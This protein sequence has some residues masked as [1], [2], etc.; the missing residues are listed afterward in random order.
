MEQGGFDPEIE[1]RCATC[2][3]VSNLADFINEVDEACNACV[4]CREVAW[5][6]RETYKA[7]LVELKVRKGGVCVDCF[8]PDLEVLQFDHRE[9][10][11]SSRLKLSRLKGARSRLYEASLCDLRCANC[12]A[13]RSYETGYFRRQADPN[14]TAQIQRDRAKPRQD[15]VNSVKKICYDS[16]CSVCHWKAYT[17]A[18]YRALHFD[19]IDPCTKVASVSSLA[20][21]GCPLGVVSD[22]ILKCTLTC[23]NCHQR[24]TNRQA[25][26]THP[27]V[28]EV[29]V[30][31]RSRPQR[32]TGT[33]IRTRF[34]FRPSGLGSGSAVR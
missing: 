32:V 6:R 16:Q 23:A 25:L 20:A 11:G 1:G 13:M 7:A 17:E 5:C 24:R 29:Q 4:V 8:N 21:S 9:F 19:H 18:A 26:L 15:F 27:R 33:M 31:V 10:T 34:K 30:Q 22:E 28:S 2:K 3:Q 14:R 12:H